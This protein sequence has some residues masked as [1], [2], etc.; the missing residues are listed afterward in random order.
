[1]PNKI[2]ANE[3]LNLSEKNLETA[4]LLLRENH[5]TD[6]IAIEIHQ[7]IEK[8]FKAV[9]AFHGLKIQRTHSLPL[10]YNL[11]NPFL[12]LPDVTLEELVVISDYY[13]TETQIERLRSIDEE[14]VSISPYPFGEMQH[15][16]CRG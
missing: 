11:I 4:R 2:Y 1:M 12:L 15:F 10:L 9:L 8:A 7:T 5:F 14:K 6:I 3:W 16:L 13:E